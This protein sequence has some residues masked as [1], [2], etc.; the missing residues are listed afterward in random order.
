MAEKLTIFTGKN[1]TYAGLFSLRG[2]YKTATG[3]LDQRGYGPY[4][5]EHTEEVYEDGKQILITVK[6]SKKVSDMATVEWESRFTF[7]KCQPVT[8]EKDEIEVSM[9][10]GTITIES[11]ALLKTNYDK[12]FEQNA[13]WYFIKVVFDKYIFQSY[14]KRAQSQ[15]KKDYSGFEAEIKDYLNM[16]RYN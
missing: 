15:A 7:I 4:D 8:I 12:S 11:E 9:F 14:L 5:A 3:Y 10:K 6:G 2:L 1:I 16:E 13:F